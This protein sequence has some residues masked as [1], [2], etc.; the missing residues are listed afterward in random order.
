MHCPDKNLLVGYVEGFV[1]EQAKQMMEAHFAECA[2]CRASFASL[3]MTRD[4]L[5]EYAGSC[6][7]EGEPIDVQARVMDRILGEHDPVFVSSGAEKRHLTMADMKKRIAL[8]GHSDPRIA[9]EACRDFTRYFY[10]YY[11]FVRKYLQ[12]LEREADV[13]T[14]L[15]RRARERVVSY[16]TQ[17][18][19]VLAY[20]EQQGSPLTEEQAGALLQDESTRIIELVSEPERQIYLARIR[21]S[22]KGNPLGC[23][24]FL[25]RIGNTT[26]VIAAAQR[27]DDDQLSRTV[28]HEFEHM[29]EVGAF[30]SR[31]SGEAKTDV[32]ADRS[33]PNQDATRR[34]VS[35]AMSQM[36]FRVDD[37]EV[38][39]RWIVQ[40]MPVRTGAG[41]VI[42]SGSSCLKIWDQI[43]ERVKQNICGNLV[44]YT[45]SD[46]VLGTLRDS[47]D[48][49]HVRQIMM[50]LVGS[51]LDVEHLAYYSSWNS[52]ESNRE[53][54]DKVMSDRFQPS[55]VYMGTS[56]V[57]FDAK[58][59]IFLGYHAGYKERATKEVF[60]QR[61]TQARII[62]VIADKIG[63]A[64]GLSIDVLGVEGLDSSPIYLV[65]TPPRSTDQK[66]MERFARAKDAF[67][68]EGMQQAISRH[69]GLVV[70]W[71]TVAASGGDAPIIKEH[72]VMPR[73]AAK[74]LRF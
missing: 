70:H 29:I 7:M 67:L 31:L 56:A 63:Y 45:N 25:A 3:Q 66:G 42:E 44:V 71:V 39:A 15:A 20:N 62:P 2:G 22:L 9:K 19:R 10:V 14:D 55:Y 36:E 28:V 58:G 52:D 16:L 11:D 6:P 12:G 4:R 46:Q 33:P 32:P 53:V 47:M 64:G 74:D 73:E 37:K 57:R 51:S 17:S 40:H 69:N 50:E 27:L 5:V 23:D 30:D 59:R 54:R 68:S 24:G 72:L 26:Y 18:A 34:Y 38:L 49:P 41:I 35:F 60:L 13:G 65:T 8:M 48:D 61:S 43:L 21:D 1:N